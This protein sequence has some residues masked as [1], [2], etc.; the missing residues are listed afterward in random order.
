MKVLVVGSGGREHALVWKLS[1]SQLVSEIYC[2]SGNAGISRIAKV[3]DIPPTSVEE[4]ADF[5][6]STGIDFTVVGPEAP[7]VKG[8]A[9]RFRER[10]LRIF[11][12]GS[13]GALLEGSKAFAKEF[14]KR[15][16]VPTADYRV[17]EDFETA[18]G[19][20]KEVGA[21]IVVKADGLAGGKGAVVCG[22]E[23]QAVDTLRALMRDRIFGEAGS[24]VVIEEFL[25]G[26]EASYI[27][28]VNGESYVPLP[29]SQDHKRLLDGD[30]GPNTGGMGAYSPT[31][32][33]DSGTEERI[34]KEIIER[35]LSGLKEEGINFVGF[36]YAGLM[37]TSEGPKV[38]EFNVRLGDPEAQPVLMRV[39]GDFLSHL[40][41]IYEG[42]LPKISHSDRWSIGVVLASEGYPERPRTGV[43]I[44]GLEE[45]QSLE[46]VVVFHAGTEERDGKVFTKGG[47]VLCVCAYGEDL[48]RARDRAYEAVDVISFE[49][50]TFRRDIGY[51]AL[52]VLS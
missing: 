39:E 7:L 34:R 31:P 25:E 33:I 42:G 13:E 8:I 10:G 6:D 1:Q 14:M 20:V 52:R 28:M 43:E 29:T 49:G 2:A 46:D 16:G 27:V 19:Y 36:L 51:R 18:V 15:H 22:S 9:D 23:E 26:E 5:A 24:R 4:L 11:G 3:V 40:L 17:F 45:A 35:T 32:F 50:K 48:R 44:K 47:R 12:P 30:R 41:E 37:L 21:P 38:L